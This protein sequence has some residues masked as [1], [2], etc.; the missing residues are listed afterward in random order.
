MKNKNQIDRAIRNNEHY[1]I[2]YTLKHKYHL[3]EYNSYDN[4]C[5]TLLKD[6]SKLYNGKEQRTN[7]EILKY[8]LNRDDNSLEAYCLLQELHQIAYQV[9]YE[10]SSNILR[11]WIKKVNSSKY[12]IGIMK[13][14]AKTIEE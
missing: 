11:I 10:N 9:P 12:E 7:Q 13:T 5:S 14:A 1:K 3:L 6:K 8:M 2:Y 4:D